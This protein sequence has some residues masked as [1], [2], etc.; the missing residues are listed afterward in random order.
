MDSP[1]IA[2]R[3]FGPMTFL[4]SRY[5]APLRRRTPTMYAVALFEK[6]TVILVFA[7]RPTVYA[8]PFHHQDPAYFGVV[9]NYRSGTQS[10]SAIYA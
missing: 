5:D 4:E 7:V 8:P 9:Q 3:Q 10:T 2:S 6:S 1:E